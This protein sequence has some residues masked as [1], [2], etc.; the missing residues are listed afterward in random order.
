MLYSSTFSENHSLEMLNVAAICESFT[1]SPFL[2][3]C[4]LIDY[5]FLFLVRVTVLWLQSQKC[6]P[7]DASLQLLFSIGQFC[8]C[9]K[10]VTSRESN[11]LLVWAPPDNRVWLDSSR[12]LFS[13]SHPS[14][15]EA[16]CLIPWPSS[17]VWNLISRMTKA[18]I[19]NPGIHRQG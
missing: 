7:E 18:V 12:A 3:N 16:S 19:P 5:C 4:C 10:L 13:Q 9:R 17:S 15:I 2:L 1:F 8:C 14:S 11:S 6:L